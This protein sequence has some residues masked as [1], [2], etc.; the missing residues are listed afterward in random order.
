MYLNIGEKNYILIKDIVTILDRDKIN[1]SDKSNEYFKK[2][3]ENGSLN[4]KEMKKVKSYIITCKEKKDKKN[5]CRK[6]EYEIYLSN[7]S[8]TTLLKRSED[9]EN[10]LEA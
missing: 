2:L 8:S 5:R 3:I 6:K 10:R 4:Q 7:I 9:I 1:Y